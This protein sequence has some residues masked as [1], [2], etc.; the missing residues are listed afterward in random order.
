MI[1]RFGCRTY[2]AREILVYRGLAAKLESGE[3]RLFQRESGFPL[4]TLRTSSR[5]HDGVS[6][7]IDGAMPLLHN[8]VTW[9]DVSIEI[10][11]IDDTIAREAAYR[12]WISQNGQL[13]VESL[14]VRLSQW[15]G[16]DLYEI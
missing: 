3:L 9:D 13:S 11:R 8:V 10:H 15:F 6:R 1:W 4:V 5:Q 12:G 7:F 16:G 14:R 2:G